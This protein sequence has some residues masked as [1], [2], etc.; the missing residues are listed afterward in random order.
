MSCIS[1]DGLASSSSSVGVGGKQESRNCRPVGAIKRLHLYNQM[2]YLFPGHV[3]TH[4]RYPIHS[5]EE[6]LPHL[7]FLRK[8]I[9]GWSKIC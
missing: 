1:V 8:E 5:G 4:F 9:E 6:V 7:V 2:Q 3:P